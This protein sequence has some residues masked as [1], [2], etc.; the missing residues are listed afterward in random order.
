MNEA[1]DLINTQLILNLIDLI[2]KW[3]I[4]PHFQWIPRDYNQL[5][6]F[7]SKFLD[8]GDWTLSN[9]WFSILEKHW[10][11]H[12]IDRMASP[13]NTRLPRFFSRFYC[14]EAEGL[15]CFS[16]PDWSNENNFVNPDFNLVNR[17]LLHMRACRSEGTIIVPDWPSQP[18]WPI[19]FP[20]NEDVTWNPIRDP[21]KDWIVLPPS[22]II[23]AHPHTVFKSGR[24]TFRVLAL[25]ISFK[26]YT[27]PH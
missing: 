16:I 7:W 2:H 13:N 1:G 14:P 10:G 20:A 27:G 9:E 6:D 22:A 17:V 25:R 21:R 11:P 26:D 12:T 15:D 8:V 18:W 24:P 3:R 23:P 4:T 5:A 19:L